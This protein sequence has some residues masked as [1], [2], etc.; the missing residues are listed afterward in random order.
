[1]L[2]GGGFY[3][4]VWGRAIDS[5]PYRDRIYGRFAWRR[6]RADH[7]AVVGGVDPLVSCSDSMW[8]E[9]QRVGMLAA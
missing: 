7:V 9:Q 1:M 2:A 8:V 6:E 3:F 5:H 4:E